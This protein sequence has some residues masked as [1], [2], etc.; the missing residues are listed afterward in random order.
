MIIVRVIRDICSPDMNVAS[1]L[2]SDIPDYH[3]ATT[4]YYLTIPSFSSNNC[5]SDV[6]FYIDDV[7]VS[8]SGYSFL[9]NDGSG[10]TPSRYFTITPPYTVRG[11]T[12]AGTYQLFW[13]TDD[14]NLAGT[15]VIKIRYFTVGYEA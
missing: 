10:S 12:T 6:E 4:A 14:Y 13:D 7:E 11:T 9:Q 8:L 2:P 5:E 15:Y 1:S 3:I